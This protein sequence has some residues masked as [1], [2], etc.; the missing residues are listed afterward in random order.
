[1]LVVVLPYVDGPATDGHLG[2]LCPETLEALRA[3]GIEPLKI[4]ISPVD[5]E[6]YWR[7]ISTM[8]QLGKTFCV[9]EQDIVPFPGAIA[10]LE[11]CPEPWCAYRYAM[12]T[13]YHAALGCA[14]FDASLMALYPRV[15]ERV[16]E[17]GQ[18]PSPP[19]GGPDDDG[20]PQR[21]W[22][23]LD[24]RIARVLTQECGV[25]IHVHDRIV[26]HLNPRQQFRRSA[27]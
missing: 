4:A 25:P 3:D 14:K 21:D 27:Q 26:D 20:V 17:I 7:A 16:G 9:V 6:G 1:M 12:Q 5:M 11:A 2:G 10:E 22:R 15:L 19:F 8:W 24:T 18:P 23:R 13:G